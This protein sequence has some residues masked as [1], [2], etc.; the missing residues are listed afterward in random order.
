MN[1]NL[2]GLLEPLM[3]A[4]LVIRI[5]ENRYV[6]TYFTGCL[7]SWLP[8][9][10]AK[11]LMEFGNKHSRFFSQ[12]AQATFLVNYTEFHVVFAG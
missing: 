9:H 8:T 2:P 11:L 3:N 7:F 5:G 4:M 6:H 1:G 10:P 12:P